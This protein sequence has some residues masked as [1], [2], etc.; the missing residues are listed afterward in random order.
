MRFARFTVFF[1]EHPRQADDR[2]Q[3]IDGAVGL[4]P[5]RVLRDTFAADQ[6]GL[7]PVARACV[8]FV[9]ANSHR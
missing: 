7:T 5:Q 2:V 8:N 1:I 9:D 3:L 6:P 4:H